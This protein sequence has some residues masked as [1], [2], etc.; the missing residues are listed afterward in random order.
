MSHEMLHNEAGFMSGFSTIDHM[1]YHTVC[2]YTH[3]ENK[4]PNKEMRS[5]AG[6]RD[7]GGVHQGD[8]VFCIQT[9]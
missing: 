3:Y 7:Y 9:I 6:P 5:I 4:G 8:L 2:I 1:I